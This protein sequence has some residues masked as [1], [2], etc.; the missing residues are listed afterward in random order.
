MAEYNILYMTTKKQLSILKLKCQNII[1]EIRRIRLLNEID[2]L[3]KE[4]DDKYSENKYFD[5]IVIKV[6]LLE[7][8]LEN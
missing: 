3:L 2:V 7:H 6:E 8:E 5:D 4:L 1:D